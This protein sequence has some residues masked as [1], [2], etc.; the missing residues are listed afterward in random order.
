MI[1]D[2]FK[3]GLPENI[4]KWKGEMEKKAVKW[5]RTEKKKWLK[6]KNKWIEITATGKAEKKLR[7]NIKKSEW[8]EKKNLRNKEEN[9]N[10]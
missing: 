8:G 4:E 3:K 5:E 7:D 10:S 6:E 2:P 9:P 1:M